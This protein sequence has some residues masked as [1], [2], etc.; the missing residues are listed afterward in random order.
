MS[1]RSRD[2]RSAAFGLSEFRDNCLLW[3]LSHLASE[4]AFCKKDVSADEDGV[5]EIDSR[6]QSIASFD[7]CAKTIPCRRAPELARRLLTLQ[8]ACGEIA[9]VTTSGFVP[10]DGGVELNQFTVLQI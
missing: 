5:A 10:G 1:L 4:K 7:S 6:A 2:A 9:R 8:N 3:I